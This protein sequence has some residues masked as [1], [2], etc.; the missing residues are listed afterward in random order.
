M[1]SMVHSSAL[2]TTVTGGV[3]PRPM[4]RAPGSGV[5]ITVTTIWAATT[6]RRV[7]VFQFVV[8]GIYSLFDLF[9]F[10]FLN[11]NK[12]RRKAGQFFF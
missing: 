10:L 5:C 8:C 6:I 7:V 12:T 4:L 11:I 1:T 9:S 3:L 2:A